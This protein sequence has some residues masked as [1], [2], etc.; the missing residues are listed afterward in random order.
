MLCGTPYPTQGD[1]RTGLRRREASI[2]TREICPADAPG[3]S[4]AHT[5]YQLLHTW[6]PSPDCGLPPRLSL[7]RAH[8][9]TGRTHQLRLHFSHIGCP[10]LG[11]DMYGLGTLPGIME[12]QALHAYQLQFPHPISGHLLTVTAP[13]PEDMRALIPSGFPECSY[14][15]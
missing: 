5:A 8:P 14:F 3:A 12:R 9:I 4:P 2:I 1:I 7:V 13:L 6:S 10:I 11:D 15:G